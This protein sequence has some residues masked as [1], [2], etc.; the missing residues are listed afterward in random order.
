MIGQLRCLH[1]WAGP[2]RILHHGQAQ[3]FVFLLLSPQCV[4]YLCEPL[5]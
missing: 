4:A 1:Y 2:R 5:I 3:S